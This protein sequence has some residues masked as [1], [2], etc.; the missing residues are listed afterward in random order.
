V[1]H[2]LTR[3]DTYQGYFISK[4]TVISETRTSSSGEKDVYDF[5]LDRYMDHHS[6][7]K[8]AVVPGPDNHSIGFVFNHAN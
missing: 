2:R 3:D 1:P 6:G 8:K 4:D 7:L 5:I